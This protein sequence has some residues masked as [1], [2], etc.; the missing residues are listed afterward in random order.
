VCI[1]IVQVSTEGSAANRI[2]TARIVEDEILTLVNRIR[3]QCSQYA[4]DFQS[5]DIRYQGYEDQEGLG[6]GMITIHR[7][8]VHL[9]EVDVAIGCL[10]G[11]Y[12]GN[13]IRAGGGR[14]HKVVPFLGSD[15]YHVGK[16]H[17]NHQSG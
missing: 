2:V 12:L 6:R 15:G 17:F 9:F 4:E 16:G 13:G 5:G 11:F 7:R 14:A 3:E 1:R 8:E 10:L